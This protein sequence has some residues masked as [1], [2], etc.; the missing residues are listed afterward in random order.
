MVFHN[1][2]VNLE[3]MLQKYSTNQCL[4]FKQRLKHKCVVTNLSQNFQAYGVDSQ[5]ADSQFILSKAQYIPSRDIPRITG[6]DTN[7]YVGGPQRVSTKPI[8]VG[9]GLADLPRL[10]G[11]SRPYPTKRRSDLQPPSELLSSYSDR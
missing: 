2:F 5:P 9:P 3:V 8:V 1:F 10:K 4:L 7:K 6:I 11:G